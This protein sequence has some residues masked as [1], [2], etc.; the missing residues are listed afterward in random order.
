MNEK[1]EYELLVEIMAYAKYLSAYASHESTIDYAEI[2]KKYV[3]KASYCLGSKSNSK[4]D[5]DSYERFME[6]RKENKKYV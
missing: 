3:S 1:K 6:L 2:I 4:I 5:Y